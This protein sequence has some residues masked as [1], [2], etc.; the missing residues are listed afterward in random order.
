MA[1][2]SSD[3]LFKQHQGSPATSPWSSIW[4][5]TRS[6]A[7]DVRDKVAGATRSLPQDID[8]PPV[9]TKADASSDAIMSLTVQ[10]DT[11]N[12]LEVSDFARTLSLR[13]CRQYRGER[14][15]LIGQKRY[16]MR[17]WMDPARL[18]AYKS[19]AA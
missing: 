19:D 1:F 12:Q 4:T 10:S 13:I 9:V 15:Q 5:P 7:N 17:L 2:R 6:A 18:A 11:R 8:A 16:A 3:H 14:T